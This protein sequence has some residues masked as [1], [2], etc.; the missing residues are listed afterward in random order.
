[1]RATFDAR[2]VARELVRCARD[3]DAD[4]LVE[5]LHA[6]VGR[7]DPVAAHVRPVIAELN[8][9]SVAAVHERAAP[10]T[11]DTLF[12][13]DLRDEGDRH[14]DVDELSPQTRAAVRALLAELNGEPADVA[15]QLDL[16]VR[17]MDQDAGLATVRQTL[18]MTIGLLVWSE[19]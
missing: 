11:A 16:A 15:Y 14:L 5:T 18:I 1:M 9:V 8:R 10:V 6:V 3:G 7:A 13:V 2:S 17:E 19:R 12:G 4:G